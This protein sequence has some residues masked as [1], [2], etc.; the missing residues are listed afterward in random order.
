MVIIDENDV[1]KLI[2]INR[3][4]DLGIIDQ[5]H[6]FSTK[7]FPYISQ[8]LFEELKNSHPNIYQ[9]LA[10]AGIH[11][12]FVLDIPK[13][14]VNLSNFGINQYEQ[15]KTRNAPW[16]DVRDLGLSWLKKADECLAQALLL[17][18]NDASLKAKTDFFA[19]SFPFISFWDVQK[20]HSINNSV[21]IYTQIS[22]M[23]EATIAELILRFG[24]CTAEHF[25]NDQILNYCLKNFILNQVFYQC[26]TQPPFVFL[27][28][29]LAVQYEEL[30]WQKSAILS[31]SILAEKQKSFQ[32]TSDEYL[33][34]IWEYITKNKEKFPC[35]E[36]QELP[37]KTKII[38]KKSGLYL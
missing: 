3:N 26:A 15:G 8:E 32:K 37:M 5:Q 28:N 9:L 29:G 38:S 6:G 22:A 7:I 1:R 35:Y 34:L 23:M 30:P 11:Y 20:F 4:F 12:S 10:K 24:N 36:P 25:F 17:I 33:T 18:S 27:T 13:I 14:K 21:D 2:S 16:W 31:P 19:N